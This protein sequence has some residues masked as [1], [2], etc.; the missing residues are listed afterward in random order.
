MNSSDTGIS[1]PA[2]IGY[3]I[4]D[5]AY[6]LPGDPVDIKQWAP[7]QGVSAK[8]VF[9]LL[10]NGCRYFHISTGKSDADLIA[11]ALD[12][13]FQQSAVHPGQ[14]SYLLHAHTQSYSIPAPPISVLSEL[15]ARYPLKP[16]LSFSVGHLACA[17][18]INSIRLATDLLAN[19]DSAT[20]A[21]IVTADRVF[22]KSMHRIRQN[23]G[24]Q[25]DGG[26][27]ILIAKENVRCRFGHF[28][29]KNFPELHEGPSTAKNVA[30]ISRS[31]W[32]QTKKLFASAEKES[33][34]SLGDYGSILPINADLPYWKLI[35]KNAGLSEQHF[36][37]DNIG[38]RGHACCADFAINLVDHGWEQ[39]KT[40]R[41]VLI[42][43]QSN[44][45][46]HATL[47]LLPVT[48]STSQRSAER[49]AVSS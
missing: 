19:D 25:S 24:I 1:E 27:A 23:A 30:A 11:G 48:D 17:S 40:G 5:A 3:G 36:F 29:V 6:H 26:S 10:K 7:E 22:G 44:V 46:A 32:L 47:A 8:L 43:G 49:Q 9:E 15:M 21:L 37:L 45:G 42:C 14:I 20:H 4:A 28:A 2:P 13:L 34:L 16:E 31:T 41:P 33:G 39:L 38:L 12:R 18:V 35:A